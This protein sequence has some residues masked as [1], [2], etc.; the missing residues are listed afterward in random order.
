MK[1]WIS[2]QCNDHFVKKR[3]KLNLISR[4]YFKIEEIDKKFLLNKTTILDLGAA[5]GG[6][7]QYFNKFSCRITGIDIL[8]IQVN[9]CIKLL[10]DIKDYKS[11]CKF[12]LILSDISSN[13]TGIKDLDQSNMINILV[14]VNQI[15]LNNLNIS[16]DLVIK[17][18]EYLSN[19]DIIKTIK[20][21]FKKYYLYKPLAS[22]RESSEIYLVSKNFIL[23]NKQIEN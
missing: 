20:L 19:D 21:Y 16:G 8:P 9:S 7:I 12:N 23:N 15:I 1:K 6:W 14:D 2:R 11:S 3:D 13:I 17:L 4:S 10:M 5:P 18:F 22:R